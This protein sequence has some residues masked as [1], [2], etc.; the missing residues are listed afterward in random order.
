VY[1][2][3]HVSFWQDADL[4]EATPEEKYFFLYILTNPHTS[5]CGIYE[6][7]KRT[8]AFETGYNTETIDKLLSRF[9]QQNRVFYDESTKEVLVTRWLKHN[10]SESPKVKKRIA[11]ELKR[12][13]SKHLLTILHNLYPEKIKQLE[14]YGYSMDTVS[15]D[16]ANGMNSLSIDYG[17]KEKEKEK[18]KEY[19]EHSSNEECLSSQDSE[20]APNKDILLNSKIDRTPYQ[21]LVDMYH[22]LCPDLPRVKVLNDTRKRLV[23]ARWREY[24]DFRFW[25]G[26]FK[27]VHESDFLNGRLALRDDKPP[28]IADFE[29]LIRPNNFAKILEGK[30]DNRKTRKEIE[31]EQY[32]EQIRKQLGI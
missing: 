25:E 14:Q 30:Y 27:R 9:I 4:I 7:S 16:Y 18:E 19:I 6:I 17:E 21:Q 26:F 20:D 28:F 15:I 13:K 2:M 32:Y 10:W 29:W 5:Q 24:P 1:R 12:V 11:E 31:E 8:M 23:R 22:S 3:V